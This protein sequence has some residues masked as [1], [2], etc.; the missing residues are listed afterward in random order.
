MGFRGWVI[1]NAPHHLCVAPYKVHRAFPLSWL[2]VVL[3]EQ[4]I[5]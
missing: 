5:P 1:G 3:L 2:M 4:E